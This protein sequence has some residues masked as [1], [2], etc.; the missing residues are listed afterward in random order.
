MGDEFEEN[1]DED[2]TP[3][4]DMSDVEDFTPAEGREEADEALSLIHI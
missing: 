2:I 4:E 1:V 3:A